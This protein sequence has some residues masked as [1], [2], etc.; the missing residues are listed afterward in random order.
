[1]LD[2]HP[3]TVLMTGRARSGAAR[4]DVAAL[5]DVRRVQVHLLRDLGGI[6]RAC[7]QQISTM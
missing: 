2:E 6:A 3:T 5:G 4:L 1:M 7:H